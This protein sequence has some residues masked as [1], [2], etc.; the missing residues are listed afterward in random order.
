MS[1]FASRVRQARDHA[2]LSQAALAARLG[3]KQQAVQ[4]LENPKHNARGSRHTTAIARECGVDA[5]WLATGKGEMLPR[6]AALRQRDASYEVLTADAQEVAL[7][8]SQLSDET[9]S[10]A[11]DL[12][13]MLA[14]MERRYPWLRRGRPRG[15]SYTDYERRI[16]QN[17]Q[18]KMVLSSAKKRTA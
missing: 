11:R 6:A 7:A 8:W 16:E 12:V 3:V 14:V 15:E 13:F 4:Y 10:W 5:N 17:F 2:G 18:A 1:T 9:K